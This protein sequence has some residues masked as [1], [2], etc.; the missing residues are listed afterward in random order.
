M[1]LN[2]NNKKII[3]KQKQTYYIRRNARPN[4]SLIQVGL[5]FK[6]LI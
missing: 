3:A 4:Y 6:L 5:C 1:R 2:F